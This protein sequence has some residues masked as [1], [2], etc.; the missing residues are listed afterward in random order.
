MFH[1]AISFES[2]EYAADVDTLGIL[3]FFEVI[4]IN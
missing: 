2:L 3:K 1:I 4:R